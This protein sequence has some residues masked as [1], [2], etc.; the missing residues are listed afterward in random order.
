LNQEN[1][2]LK[3]KQLIKQKLTNNLNIKFSKGKTVIYIYCINKLDESNNTFTKINCHNLTPITSHVYEISNNTINL[4]NYD[5][6]LI[7]NID[8]VMNYKFNNC[9]MSYKP[10][11]IPNNLIYSHL[12]LKSKN[13]YNMFKKK[14]NKKGIY[15]V[16]FFQLINI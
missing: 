6:E 9:S 12:N 3:N 2:S 7:G 4:F 10:I 13:K 5:F 14:Y 1:I 15:K 8:F 16:E 11:S